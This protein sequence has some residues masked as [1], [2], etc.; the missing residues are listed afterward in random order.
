MMFVLQV[1]GH[2]PV[3]QKKHTAKENNTVQKIT[4]DHGSKYKVQYHKHGMDYYNLQ[5]S[6]EEIVFD[7]LLEDSVPRFPSW[8]TKSKDVTTELIECR[9]THLKVK[10]IILE[11]VNLKAMAT[12][13]IHIQIWIKGIHSWSGSDFEFMSQE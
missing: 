3:Y 12:Q 8:T 13:H 4:E 11:R 5:L 6:Q 1:K 9:Q 2:R 7:E 10:Q